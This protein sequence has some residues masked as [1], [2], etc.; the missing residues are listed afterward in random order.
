MLETG[1]RKSPYEIR[2]RRTVKVHCTEGDLG[3]DC[4]NDGEKMQIDK[5]TEGDLKDFEGNS[6]MKKRRRR[7]K[8][9]AL[10][11]IGG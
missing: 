5:Q 7:S 8:G 10:K 11:M 3:E 4:A 2:F 9:D 6:D 1:G